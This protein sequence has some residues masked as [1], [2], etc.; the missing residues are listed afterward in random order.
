MVICSFSRW[1][2]L[3]LD[4]THPFFAVIRSSSSLPAGVS[5]ILPAASKVS[6]VRAGAVL[7]PA[8]IRKGTAAA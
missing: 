5:A 7:L 2:Q 3:A 8:R 4:Y 6:S 1:Y